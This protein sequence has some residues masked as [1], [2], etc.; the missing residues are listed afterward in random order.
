ME[1]DVARHAGLS[2]YVHVQCPEVLQTSDSY[3]HFNTLAKSKLMCFNMMLVCCAAG[4]TKGQSSNLT[5]VE[6]TV[7]FQGPSQPLDWIISQDSLA[8]I[9]GRDGNDCVLGQGSFGRLQV[10]W[11]TE[12]IATCFV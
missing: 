5:S 1:G 9:Q 6:S 8:V 4:S 7:S 11:P 3:A 10:Q 2:A 12:S